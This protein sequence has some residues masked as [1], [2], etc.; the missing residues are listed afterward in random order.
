VLQPRDSPQ[1]LPLNNMHMHLRTSSSTHP[2]H[3]LSI[4]HD[5]TLKVTH[6]TILIS[7][8]MVLRTTVA[9][10][11]DSPSIASHVEIC[12]RSLRTTIDELPNISTEHKNKISP[13]SLNNEL[14]RF[15]IWAADTEAHA[16]GYNSLDYRLREASHLRGRVI[17]LLQHL[18][19]VLQEIFDIITG[20]RVPDDNLSDSDSDDSMYSPRD[21]EQET[22][23]LS[24]L[25]SS[26]PEIT[27]CLMR[28]SLSA[29]N[30]AP[31]DQFTQ[32][33][34]IS[35]DHF[36]AFDVS[37]VRTKFPSAEEFL[38][39]RLGK[40]IT[41]RRQHLRYRRKN[42]RRLDQDSDAPLSG[43]NADTTQLVENPNIFTTSNTSTSNDD[44]TSP[45][46]SCITEYY[47]DILFQT[48]Y[49]SS[50]SHAARLLPPTAPLES[51]DTEPFECPLC[52][53]NIITSNDVEWDEHVFRDIQPYVSEP[54]T[55]I[56]YLAYSDHRCAHL[57]SAIHLTR[58]TSQ[59]I[60]GSNMRCNFIVRSGS[61]P[62]AAT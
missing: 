15:R 33:T 17:Q 40:A 39:V 20:K 54:S 3:P 28:L 59:E 30:P 38:V 51:F 52:F 1:I 60:I 29:R 37:H 41:R 62:L 8:R 34:H 35:M 13:G 27:T 46:G 43:G 16:R 4:K 36:E 6:S 5:L 7:I 11:D 32:S 19:T 12:L 47:E 49:S 24:Q 61:V 31:H 22:T 50:S 9:R 55:V 26:I 45:I 44:E 58:L 18:D 42:R 21:E 14:G 10:S 56:G 48:S 25:V 2:S 57:L 53:Q 23:E